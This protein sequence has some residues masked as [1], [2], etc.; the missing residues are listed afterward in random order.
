MISPAADLDTQFG[1]LLALEDGWC[2]AVSGAGKVLDRGV[3]AQALTFFEALAAK[4]SPTPHLYPTE[5]GGVRAEWSTPARREVS[6]DFDAHGMYLHNLD[7]PA[8]TWE[9]IETT[10]DAPEPIVAALARLLVPLPHT[11]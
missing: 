1:R 9:E 7:M 8:D 5:D 4:G 10:H 2:D 3:L 11:P 6:I